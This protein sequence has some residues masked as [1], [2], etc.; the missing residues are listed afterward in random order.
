MV[1]Y[2]IL[3]GFARSGETLDFIEYDDAVSWNESCLV[4]GAKIHEEHVK[5]VKV[6]LEVSLDL[7]GG[8]R[9][10]YDKIGGILVLGKF[11]CYVAF[12]D[13]PCA[14]QHNSRLAV[15][16][17]L[18]A[19]QSVVYLAFHLGFLFKMHVFYQNPTGG[20]KRGL[21]DFKGFRSRKITRFQEFREMKNHT[22]SRVS[23]PIIKEAA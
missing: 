16:C 19:E 22:F 23:C 6:F 18:P 7:S 14:V 9:E 12:A 3:D 10:I 20:V 1:F 8:C 13:S 11:L 15:A 17:A 4:R 21:V 2:Q 5:V